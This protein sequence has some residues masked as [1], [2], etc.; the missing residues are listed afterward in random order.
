MTSPRSPHDL[1]SS[2]CPSHA[3]HNLVAVVNDLPTV[4]DLDELR[5][6][7]FRQVRTAAV[8]A[9]IEAALSGEA[10]AF[11]GLAPAPPPSSP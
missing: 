11:L 1:P 4:L 7:T 10:D 2:P 3:R 6:E 9:H 5:R 8:H